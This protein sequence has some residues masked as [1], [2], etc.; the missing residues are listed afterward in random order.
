MGEFGFPFEDW[1]V[2]DIDE[3]CLRGIEGGNFRF[4]FLGF[5]FF[6]KGFGKWVDIRTGFWLLRLVFR[7]ID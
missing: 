6:L 3:D 5:V 4:F 7:G 1:F 2:L